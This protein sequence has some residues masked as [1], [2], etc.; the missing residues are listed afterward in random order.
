MNILAAF[1]PG[2]CVL[3]RRRSRCDVD[4]CWECEAAFEHNERACPVCAEPAPSGSESAEVCGACIVAPPPWT[5]T[6]APFIYGAPLSRVVEGLKSGNGLREAR[7]LGGL[8]GPAIRARYRR[9]VLPDALIP[10]PLTRR[11]RR[12]RGY[13]QAELLASVVGR[14]VNRPVLKGKLVRT[15]HTP[16]QRTLPRSARLR[17]VRGVFDVRRTVRERVFARTAEAMPKR[18]ALVDDVTTTGATVRSAS[19][20]LRAAGVEE[21]HVWVAAKTVTVRDS[22]HLA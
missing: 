19:E 8:L 15:R 18:V 9:D 22:L 20:T 10:M 11:R 3:C 17:N 2:I 16:P 14:A 7:I 6:V 13:N 21:V 4:L 12:Q 5:V 1:F